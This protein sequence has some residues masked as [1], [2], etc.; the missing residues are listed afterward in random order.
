[1]SKYDP[2]RRFLRRRGTKDVLLTF[3]EIERIIGGFLPKAAEAPG[4]WSNTQSP[5][6]N[7]IQSAAWLDAGYHAEPCKERERIRFR[8]N[9]DPK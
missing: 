8:Q 7:R 1:M 3:N 4:W 2:L 5:E 6:R 9:I